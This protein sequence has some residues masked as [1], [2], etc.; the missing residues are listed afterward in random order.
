MTVRAWF[1]I[2]AIVLVALTAAVVYRLFAPVPPPEIFVRSGEVRLKGDRLAACWPGRSGEVGCAQPQ[3]PS[4]PNDLP[5]SG[6]LRFVV[7][8]PVQ[9]KNGSIRIQRLSGGTVLESRWR[10]EIVYELPPGTYELQVEARYP[11]DAYLIYRF[12]LSINR[13]GS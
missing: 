10:R 11:E 12:L 6:R 2:S 5:T 4:S 7:G 8:F 3:G 9:P 1:T 13:A